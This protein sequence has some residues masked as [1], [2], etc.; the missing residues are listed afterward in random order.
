MAR[1]GRLAF[2]S[3]YPLLLA[4]LLVLGLKIV[5]RAAAMRQSPTKLLDTVAGEAT[6]RTLELYPYEGFHVQANF[7]HRGPMPWDDKHPDADFDVRTGDRGFFVDFPLDDPPPKGKDEFRVI[8]IGGS[9]AQGWGG[10]R[11][12]TMFYA[13]L[14]RE[15]NARLAAGGA[16]ARVVNLAMGGT[17]AYQNFIALN[18]YARRLEPDL[19]LAYVG[20]NDFFVPLYHER[21]TDLPLGFNELR[22]FT[23]ATRG[24]ECPPGLRWLDRLMPNLMRNTSIGLGLKVA[25]GWPH[26]EGRARAD[27]AQL[28]GRRVKPMQEVIDEVA[29]PQLVNSLASI[30][31]DFGG[32]PVLVAWQA[33]D[34]EFEIFKDDLDPGFYGRMYDR[35]RS[36]LAGYVN[37]AWYFFNVH[38]LGRV[39]PEA[40]FGTHLDDA[41]HAVTGRALADEIAPLVPGLL[42]E[43]GRRQAAG[44]PAYGR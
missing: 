29:V 11:N 27:Y 25:L 35:V 14:E 5:D 21:K 23:L 38:D 36:E 31:R 24:S 44:L 1:L 42:A 39:N 41:A 33:I 26:Y 37:P 34:R 40:G 18:R 2:L 3:I 43:R 30:K 20:R 32:V 12:D 15:L 9:G 17:V 4:C 19:I 13:V 8:L 10:T 6:I 22:A 28:T 16:R 7:H